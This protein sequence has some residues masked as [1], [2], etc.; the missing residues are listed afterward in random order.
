V[1]RLVLVSVAYF[2]AGEAVWTVGIGPYV[3]DVA[4]FPE[5]RVGLLF[6][7]NMLAVFCCQF[8]VSRWAEG[9][10]RLRV[11]ACGH[12][13]T[14]AAFVVVVAA[15]RTLGG[16][17]LFLVLVVV[18]IAIG[19]G[20]CTEPP[21]LQ[22][23]LLDAVP[24]Q[25]QGRALALVGKG[26]TVGM[27]GGTAAVGLLLGWSADA[28]WIAGALVLVASAALLTATIVAPEH[29]HVPQAR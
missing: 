7:A 5:S 27:A 9:R 10:S 6:A 12:L 29:R 1:S 13:V 18:A 4:G 16:T 26:Q 23:L 15:T 8:V 19:A 14:A 2:L 25:L 3:K 21:A 20:E 28:L 17:S 24:P 11:L 22:P